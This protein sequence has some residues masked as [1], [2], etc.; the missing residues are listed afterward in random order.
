M[1]PVNKIHVISPTKPKAQLKEHIKFKYEC[2]KKKDKDETWS[3][4]NSRTEVDLPGIVKKLNEIPDKDNSA[5]VFKRSRTFETGN[6]YHRTLFDTDN[7]KLDS[8][9][10]FLS[11]YGLKNTFIKPI[12]GLMTI[13]QQCTQNLKLTMSRLPKRRS[14]EGIKFFALD[15]ASDFGQKY[16]IKSKCKENVPLLLTTS[17]F[18]SD[19]EARSQVLDFIQNL[20]TM[21][22][23]DVDQK[24]RT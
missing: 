17:A 14:L 3:L 2:F 9:K 12:F 6:G 4:D 7:E 23:Q 8:F 24:D 18:D 5:V 20:A 13:T 1:E 21:T 19:D 10:K 11:N 15:A 22:S 16:E